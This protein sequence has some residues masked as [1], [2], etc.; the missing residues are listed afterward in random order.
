MIQF[1]WA[2]QAGL[3]DTSKWAEIV[4]AVKDPYSLL[5]LIV[6]VLGALAYRM[7]DPTNNSP[8]S[9]LLAFAIAVIALLALALN[10]TRIVNASTTGKAEAAIKPPIAVSILF[11]G[12]HAT[13]QSLTV[14]FQIGSGQVN[15]GCGESA[16]PVVNFNAPQGAHDINASAQWVNT[17]NVK[18]QDQRTTVAGT[19]ISASGVITGLDRNWIGNCPGGGHGELVLK[20]T[21]AIDRP[22]DREPI[23]KSIS[24]TM[25]RGEEKSFDLPSEADVTAE[26][27]EINLASGDKSYG[28]IVLRLARQD[29]IV[30]GHVQEKAGNVNA[31]IRDNKLVVQVK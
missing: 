28:H 22:G 11:R 13:T 24:A 21:Y 27:C 30:T 3:P 6:L 8:A 9:R 19:S 23:T 31:S 12:S 15:F 20:G 17:D 18:G 29:D 5:A 14:P 7:I 4:K 2:M 1:L 26:T 10:V 16:H 25:V